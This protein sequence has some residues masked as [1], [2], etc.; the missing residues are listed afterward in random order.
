MVARLLAGVLVTGSVL[1][2]TPDSELSDPEL[3]VRYCAECHGADGRGDESLLAG[4]QE[5]NLL[6]SHPIADG[7]RDFVYR[8]IA[9]GYDQMPAYIQEVEPETLER[10][11]EFTMRLP[12]RPQPGSEAGA[13]RPIQDGPIENGPLEALPTDDAPSIDESQPEEES[14]HGSTTTESRLSEARSP[15]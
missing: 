4:G 13:D 8:R 6:A 12:A 10:L 7:D 2:C 15:G 14:H 3:F 5:V 9:Y 11:V 1:A